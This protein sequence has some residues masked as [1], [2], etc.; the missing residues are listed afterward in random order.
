MIGLLLAD[1]VFV[2][3]PDS[4]AMTDQ[5]RGRA[6]AFIIKGLTHLSELHEGWRAHQQ[7]PVST[8]C[9]FA[10]TFDLVSLD[11]PPASLPA[12]SNP[13]KPTVDDFNAIDCV[14]ID[15]AVDALGQTKAAIPDR[16]AR[17]AELAADATTVA[18]FAG[19][20]PADAFVIFV[21]KY[22]CHWMGYT[23]PYPLEG[24][25]TL[26]PPML[27]AS[28]WKNRYDLVAAHETGHIFQAPDEYVA[29]NLTCDPTVKSGPFGVV[30][31]NC[32]LGNPTG[33]KCLMK[34]SDLELCSQTPLHWGWTDDD[35]DGTLDL[36]APATIDSF[37][38]VNPRLQVEEP[39]GRVAEPGWT[40]IIKGRNVWDA[41]LVTFGGVVSPHMWL[42]ALDELAA[43]IP[44]EVS[45]IVNVA[46]TTR[47]GPANATFEQSWILVTQPAPPPNNGPPE[48][49]GLIPQRGTPGT[50]VKILGASLVGPTRITFGHV[51]ANLSSLPPE[52]V[53]DPHQIEIAVP[54]APQGPGP[55]PVIV[56]TARGSSTPSIF[57]SFTYS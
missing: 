36:L 43:T 49:F 30:N 33:V 54:L 12:V 34:R 3:G 11:L 29:E 16:K 41:R 47:A 55:V 37:T 14:W 15:A 44:D 7:P 56:T 20:N 46:F 2:D 50:N 19:F 53:Q 22:P 35:H 21:T 10:V 31:S 24:F 42:R 26:C 13:K 4:A 25:S 48:V 8:S 28:E 52:E 38:V 9:S 5:E 18:L 23:R 39:D 57:S 45:G 27:D 51:E 1:V 40:V 6:L 32:E 17:I